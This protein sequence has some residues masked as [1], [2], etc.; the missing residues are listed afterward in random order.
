[1][2]FVALG[3]TNLLVSRTSFG[4]MS[5]DCKEI[6]AFGEDAEEKACALVHQAYDVGVNF[7]DTA[8]SKPVCEQRLGAALHGIRHHVFLATKTSAS[9]VQEL[10]SDLRESLDALETDTIDLYQL[11]NPLILP[12]D[13]SA[14]G[15]YAEFLS[16]K[17]K[18]I[19]KHFGI[20]TDNLD[21]AR[22]AVE[23]GLYETVQI[24]FNVLSGDDTLEVIKLCEKKDVGCIAMQ[25]LNGGVVSNIP[26]A[27][28]FLH[29]FENVIPVWGAHTQ[30][31]LQQIL[32]F[33]DHPPL[34]DEDFKEEVCRTRDFF[35]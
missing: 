22:Q 4:A 2:E 11:E 35:N 12:T 3:R 34:V 17:D 14:D 25:P 31:E 27:F 26:L 5:L 9:S 13:K 33:N 16:L 28:G 19:I 29:Q 15:L 23:S 20:A 1:M 18:K 30:E 32:Y 10:R 21:I 24:P 7:F 8:H 6:E